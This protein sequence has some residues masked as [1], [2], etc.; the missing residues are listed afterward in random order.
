VSFSIESVSGGADLVVTGDW[1]TGAR[2]AILGGQADGL[3]LNYAR[4][5]RQ[6]PI[7]FIRGLPLRRLDL[8]A[9]SVSDLSPVYALAATL[10]ELRVQSDPRAV[11]ELE[12][13][14]NLTTLAAS[15]PQ[16]QGSIMFSPRLE[17]LLPSSYQERDLAPLASLSSLRYLDMAERPRLHSLDGLE[18]FPWLSHLGV[19]WARD[20]E[21]VTAL[22]RVASPVL[23]SLALASCKKVASVESVASCLSL[24]FFDL[25]EGGEIPT[26]G[27]LGHLDGLEGLYL[28]GSTKIADGD[29]GPIA[30]LPRL[31]DLRIMARR[32]YVPS[33]EEVQRAIGQRSPNT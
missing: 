17:F 18:A 4:G 32:H 33:V 22:Q 28:Y 11:I 31:W 8:L 16:I 5:F 3:V 6:Q 23:V 14:P 15:W 27:P 20:L 19:H 7:D 26:V 2:D 25:S 13:L 1:T 12:R 9:R 10:E 24:Q 29:L 30:R 21:D